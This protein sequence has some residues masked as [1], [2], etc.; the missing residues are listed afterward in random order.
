MT[1]HRFNILVP[2]AAASL[3]FAAI[4]QAEAE[5]T[6]RITVAGVAAP[7]GFM[8]VAL[9]DERGWSG[10]PLARAR[11]AVAAKTVTLILPAPA[12]GRYGVKLFHDVNG[13][14]KMDTNIM[15]FPAEPV[16]FSNDAPIRLGPPSFAD[17]AFDIGPS[18]A[19]QVITLN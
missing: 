5:P 16:G 2:L 11:V 9:H 17:A 7:Q 18:G 14:G 12:P 19:A 3:A 8:M 1:S 10:A 15:G 13:D 4:P 6:V